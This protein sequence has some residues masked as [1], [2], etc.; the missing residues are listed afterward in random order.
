MT[1]GQPAG[2]AR[3]RRAGRVNLDTASSESVAPMGEGGARDEGAERMSRKPRRNRSTAFKAKV[4]IGALADGMAIA[5]LARK[6]D[7]DPTQVTE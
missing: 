5:E 1:T 6:H 4:A 3:G 2:D 7:V